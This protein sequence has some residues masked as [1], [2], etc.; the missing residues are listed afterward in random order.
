M[1]QETAKIL[2]NEPVAPTVYR[3]GLTGG[4]QYGAA[5]PGQF[6]TLRL[7][8]DAA[9]L[10][11]RPFSIHRVLTDRSAHKG[12]EILYKAVGGFTRKLSR[13]QEGD[14]IDLLGPL[15]HGFTV[16]SE[17][18]S[19]AL[20]AGG[21]G[22]A[23]M[24]FLA[25]R[26]QDAG[27]NFPHSAVCLGGRS[28]EDILCAADFQSLSVNTRIATEDGSIGEK[29]LVTSLLADWLKS[30]QPDMIYACGPM[31]MLSAVSAIA[32]KHQLPCQV[33]IETIM[34]CGVG[35]CL[36]CAVKDTE[37]ADGYGHVCID[38]PVFDADRVLR[39]GY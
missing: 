17:I 23:P 26:L 11:R 22:V 1:R 28:A 30:N 16:S 31:P 8:E 32:K 39:I 35:A 2:W 9:P 21:I 38:G 36:G 14:I 13:Q 18:R 3:I 20:V 29:G 7:P 24:I 10:L 37:H 15:G 25:E 5:D 33:S 27:T 6:V 12:I 34:A 4:A 19:A